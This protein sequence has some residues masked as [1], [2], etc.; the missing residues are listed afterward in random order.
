MGTHLTVGDFTN[1]P[2]NE[3]LL[4]FTKLSKDVQVKRSPRISI[5][6][7]SCEAIAN[8]VFLLRN[9]HINSNQEILPRINGN[10][11]VINPFSIDD[12]VENRSTVNVRNFSWAY[13]FGKHLFDNM[14]ISFSTNLDLNWYCVLK[15]AHEQY[16]IADIYLKYN[17]TN[18]KSLLKFLKE[19]SHYLEILNDIHT[20]ASYYFNNEISLT[21]ELL[22]DFE[23]P[24]PPKLRIVISTNFDLL[25]SHKRLKKFKLDWFLEYYDP[26]DVRIVFSVAI[27]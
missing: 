14:G 24:E 13:N 7:S 3:D 5:T 18:N 2:Y 10:V 8:S 17:F 11:Q 22:E 1:P 16:S 4:T 9:S 27:Q 25:E 26:L 15:K 12:I 19:N 23:E 20:N 6:P 21:I